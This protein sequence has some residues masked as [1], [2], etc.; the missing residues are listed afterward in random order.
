MR[1]RSDFYSIQILTILFLL[2]GISLTAQSTKEVSNSTDISAALIRAD[3]LFWESY[4]TCD[5]ETMKT[6][7]TAD[8]EFYHDKG[9][10]TETLSAFI[11]SLKNGLC[12]NEDQH[13]RREAVSGSVK[14]YPL[15]N[16]GAI[17]SGEHLFYLKEKG[18]KERA[19][20]R[21]RFT[22]VWKY[23]ND[24]WKMSRVMSYD[25]QPVA[26]QHTKQV[27]VLSDAVLDQFVGKY[28][29][30]KTGSISIARVDHALQLQAGD[31]KIII[32]PETAT[33][34]FVKERDLQFQFIKDDQQKVSTMVIYE[35]GEVVDEARRGL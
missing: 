29:S 13:L 4:N 25:H 35:N 34:F 8:L 31:F 22:H 20:S 30:A 7:F 1:T 2:M 27:T 33:R 6:F 28:T 24:Q 11:G 14:I 15:N 21:A 10:L 5:L 9:G 17:L 18:K 3:S 26:Y 23:E 16:Y 12:A 19:E 32:H